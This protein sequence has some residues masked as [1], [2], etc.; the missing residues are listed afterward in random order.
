MFVQDV[1]TA[2]RKDQIAP[3]GIRKAGAD[4]GHELS[5]G[6][7]ESWATERPSRAQNPGV[8]QR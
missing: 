5:A 1:R 2:V 7:L 4:K 3:V 8:E 6:S